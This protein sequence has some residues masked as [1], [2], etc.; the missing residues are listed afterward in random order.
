MS[1]DCFF[2]TELTTK[3]TWYS[4]IMY[5]I[6][7]IQN[8]FFFRC[9]ITILHLC[10]ITNSTSSTYSRLRRFGPWRST[11]TAVSIGYENICMYIVYTK[12]FFV[13]YSKLMYLCQFDANVYQ[14]RVQDYLKTL[15]IQVFLSCQLQQMM[16][17]DVDQWRCLNTMDGQRMTCY[18]SLKAYL[19]KSHFDGR[20]LD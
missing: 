2:A 14:L 5:I 3:F 13:V 12:C 9:C 10:R 8:R 18:Y 7:S 1:H 16:Q 17:I 15:L 19:N 11:A 4:I 6:F 20:S